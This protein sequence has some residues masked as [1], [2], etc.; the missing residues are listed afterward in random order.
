MPL[1]RGEMKKRPQ[2]LYFEHPGRMSLAFVE[3]NPENQTA[4]IDNRYKIVS[5]DGEKTYQLF[6][7]VKDP[8]ED[9]DLAVAHPHIVQQMRQNLEAWRQSCRDSA[10]GKD[11]E[12]TQRKQ[13][14]EE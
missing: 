11:Y 8:Q 12:R 10:A 14:K 7:L 2:P 1:L 13:T 9:R 3:D 5:L 4:V 6:D